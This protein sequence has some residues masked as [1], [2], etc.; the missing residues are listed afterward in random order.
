MKTFSLKKNS[1]YILV[2]ISMFPLLPKAVE[3]ILMIL[4][5]LVSLI[6]F[7]K[8]KKHC[9][10]SN[11]FQVFNLSSLFVIYLISTLYSE[12]LSEA[13][14][15]ILRVTPIFLFAL[16][17]GILNPIITKKKKKF[18]LNTYF[19]SVFTA[20]L[21]VHTHL[22][23]NVSGEITSWEYRNAFEEYTK[24]HGTYFSLWT[25]FAVL[26]IL[27]KVCN[28]KFNKK[29]FIIISLYLIVLSY[30]IYWQFI[31][32]A[33]LPLFVTL[34]LSFVLLL[35][36]LEKRIAIYIF[37]MAITLALVIGF[38]N[39]NTIK[40]K[41]DFKIP[42][43]K[44][45]LKHNVMSSEDIRAGIYFCSYKIIKQSVLYGIGIGDVNDNL[46][47]CYESEIDSDVYQIFH[48]NSHN[49]YLQIILA[50][51]LLGLL[52]FLYNLLILLKLSIRNKDNLFFALN[53]FLIICFFTENILSR[54]DGVIFYSFFTAIFYFNKEV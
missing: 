24:V 44:Y 53:M 39:L 36:Q 9:C 11:V 15:F 42:Q 12:N 27:N 23:F 45:E 3:S 40:N 34:L 17:L 4:F 47:K 28:L 8:N 31:I 54:H 10:K 41:I 5:F 46:N 35:K 25:G 1:F 38:V 32:A 26:I 52:F 37:F 51:G 50:S 30:C 22:I 6:I 20:L 18:L 21:I 7:F 29:N 19:F 49:Q 48:Y 43:G 33:R 16:T 13:F 2:L 14:N